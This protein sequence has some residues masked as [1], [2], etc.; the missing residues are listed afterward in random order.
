VVKSRLILVCVGFVSLW[1]VFVFGESASREVCS[2]RVVSKL[3][4]NLQEEASGLKAFLETRE[5]SRLSGRDKL[6]ACSRWYAIKSYAKSMSKHY[7]NA[8]SSDSTARM[9]DH[10][11]TDLEENNYCSENPTP[12]LADMLEGVHDILFRT[13]RIGESLVVTVSLCQLFQ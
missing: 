4:Q 5:Q 2:A 6:E 1:S 9:L 3:N 13:A 11:Q 8:P 12:V 10:L 7:L